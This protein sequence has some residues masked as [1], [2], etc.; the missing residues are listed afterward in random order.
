MPNALGYQDEFRAC[1]TDLNS[2]GNSKLDE[3][4][5]HLQTVLR[6]TEMGRT[7]DAQYSLGD[8]CQTV[9]SHW[10]QTIADRTCESSPL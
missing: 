5:S 9:K 4:E 2:T 8:A 6:R 7:A 3:L 10:R 1:L